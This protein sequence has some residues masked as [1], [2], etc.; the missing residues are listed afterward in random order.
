MLERSVEQQ[1]AVLAGVRERYGGMLE[2]EKRLHEQ[3]KQELEREM[4][5]TSSATR[6]AKAF[7]LVRP[8]R[9]AQNDSRLRVQGHMAVIG[10]AAWQAWSESAFEWRWVHFCRGLA[11]SG[12]ESRGSR[13]ERRG[14]W[15]PQG[16]VSSRQY[17]AKLQQLSRDLER[18]IE[19]AG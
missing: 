17:V 10:L 18:D 3:A 16:H 11:S 13:A 19:M 5:L 1:V 8:C 2:K 7:L 14:L 6:P 12:E 15:Q 9:Q 4:E